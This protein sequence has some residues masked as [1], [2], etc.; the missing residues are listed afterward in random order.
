M[1]QKQHRT[2]AD[3]CLSNSSLVGKTLRH[4]TLGHL[5]ITSVKPDG[6]QVA[7]RQF[8][9]SAGFVRED[10]AMLFSAQDIQK[11]RD[12]WLEEQRLDALREAQKTEAARL[13]AERAK[14]EQQRLLEEA[15]LRL[16]PIRAF[17]D[18]TIE[19]TSDPIPSRVNIATPKPDSKDWALIRAWTSGR[20]AADSETG[21][22]LSARLAE[23]A[24]MSFFED[25]GTAVTDVSI[26]QLSPNEFNWKLYDLEASGMHIDVKNARRSKRNPRRYVSH[27]VPQFKQARDSTAVHVAGVLSPWNTVD[28]M[29]AAGTTV[30]FLGLTNAK[31]IDTL[32]R[33]LDDGPLRLTLADGLRGPKFLPPWLFNYPDSDYIARKS[34]LT[35]LQTLPFPDWRLCREVSLWPLPAFLASGRFHDTT[36]TSQLTSGQQAFLSL[37]HDRTKRAPLT[38]PV[39]F[40]SLLEHFLIL[41]RARSP[42]QFHVDKYALLIFPTI[43]RTR[44]F[45]LYDPLETVDTLLSTLST[46][47]SSTTSLN[48]FREFRLVDLN[49]LVGKRPTDSRWITLF[50]YCGGW[51]EEPTLQPC[52]TTPLVFGE[53][54]TCSCG[55]LICPNCGFCSIGCEAFRKR[56]I[57]REY[58]VVDYRDKHR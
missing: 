11:L 44:P 38:L 18:L 22:M 3:W 12:L 17:I 55:K 7:G 10:F 19:A 33:M 5:H 30:L 15:R 26:G 20:P 56:S 6:F 13:A 21:R 49:I 57:E 47:W 8:L 50:A 32:S 25:K 35:K 14:E 4:P 9:I 34:A 31:K 27:C 48:D 23:K 41:L 43:D 58:N 37:L 54:E 2:L 24:V 28:E 53:C 36:F 1:T 39:V 29:S 46:M 42:D 16:A 40:L 45:F 52:A 51:I